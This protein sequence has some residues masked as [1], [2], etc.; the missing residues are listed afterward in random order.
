MTHY[1]QLRF[2]CIVLL[3]Y[4]VV[5]ARSERLHDRHVVPPGPTLPLPDA[6]LPHEHE[7]CRPHDAEVQHHRHEDAENGTEIVQDVVSLVR[8]H[9]ED[10]VQQ[11]EQCERSE[12]WEETVVEEVARR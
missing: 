9:D 7:S 10:R 1:R 11:T 8:E 12:E 6:Q 2:L 4:E 3:T 5:A